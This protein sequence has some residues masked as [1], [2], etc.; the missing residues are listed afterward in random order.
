MTSRTSG[1]VL[2]KTSLDDKLEVVL[3][4]KYTELVIILSIL[5]LLLSS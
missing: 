5:W 4:A 3:K 2:L 1:L